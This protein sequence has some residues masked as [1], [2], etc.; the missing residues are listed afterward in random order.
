MTLKFWDEV[1]LNVS[2]GDKDALFTVWIKILVHNFNKIHYFS[3]FLTSIHQSTATL[4][5]KFRQHNHRTK[6]SDN[7]LP[8]CCMLYAVGEVNDWSPTVG[9]FIYYKCIK[10]K[11]YLDN[12][13][14]LWGFLSNTFWECITSQLHPNNTEKH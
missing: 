14:R 7:K 9:Q 2:W 8:R 3:L 11:L 1:I 12:F 6:Y 5:F 13:R 4:K 10:L